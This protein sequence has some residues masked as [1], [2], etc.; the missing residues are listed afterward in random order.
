ME[1]RR[2]SSTSYTAGRGLESRIYKEQKSKN[3]AKQKNQKQI[4]DSIKNWVQKKAEFSKEEMKMA[5][6]CGNVQH[7]SHQ[8]NVNYNH[9]EVYLTPVRMANRI[10]KINNSRCWEELGKENSY[11]LHKVMQ[12]LWKSMWCF[13]RKLGTNLLQDPM[14]HSRA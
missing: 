14:N 5:E 7:L 13:L 10:N 11:S 12:P 2:K 8:E 6:K 4:N 9:F 1:R 3:K